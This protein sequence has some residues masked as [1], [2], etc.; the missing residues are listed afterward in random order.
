MSTYPDDQ[1]SLLKGQPYAYSVSE[2]FSAG[3]RS[4]FDLHASNVYILGLTGSTRTL[5]C[6][7][8]GSRQ[9][10]S[11]NVSDNSNGANGNHASDRGAAPNL[12]SNMGMMIAFLFLVV[13]SVLLL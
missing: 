1:A 6:N 5:L 13:T 12:A 9:Q 3:N 8:P 2:P 4:A 7:R 10:I 11:T